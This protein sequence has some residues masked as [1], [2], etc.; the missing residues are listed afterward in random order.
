MTPDAILVSTVVLMDAVVS[1][2]VLQPLLG[3]F[4]RR[5]LYLVID[6]PNKQ[7]T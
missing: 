3:F 5:F 1:L 7:G 6:T 4:K 2:T